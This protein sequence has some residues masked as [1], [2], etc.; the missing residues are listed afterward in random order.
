[1]GKIEF[2]SGIQLEHSE[3][4]EYILKFRVPKISISSDPTGGHLKQAKREIL[5]AVR[6]LIDEAI[7]GEEK[8]SKG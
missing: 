5:L 4:D 7:E 6:S 2:E 8:K 1:M 3:G